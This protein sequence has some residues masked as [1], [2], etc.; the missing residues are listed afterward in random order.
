MEVNFD[1]EKYDH[2]FHFRRMVKHT[3]HFSTFKIAF[4]R[5]AKV[6]AKLCLSVAGLV[7]ERRSSVQGVRL[8]SR[9]RGEESRAQ[10]AH[11]RAALASACARKH[12]LEYG[13][14]YI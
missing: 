7:R 12:P 10:P 5:C 2:Y 8:R 1:K 4:Q 9:V 14:R 11:N 3:V 13:G 6:V